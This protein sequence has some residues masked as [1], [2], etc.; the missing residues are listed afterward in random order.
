MVKRRGYRVE[1]GEIE[2]AS[3]AIRAIKE[4]AVDRR[5]DEEAGVSITRVPELPRGQA[6]SLIELKR[7]CSEN[8]PLYMIPERFVWLDEL[9]KTSTDKVDYQRAEGARLMDFALTEEQKLLRDN[10]VSSPT[11]AERRRCRARPRAGVLARAVAKVREMAQGPAGA[12]GVRRQRRSTRSPARSP[13]RRWA[14]AAATAAWCSRSART[15]SPAWC[16]VW[17]ARQRGAEAALPAGPVRRHAGR[18]A[19]DDRAGLG[20]GRLRDADARRARRRRLAHQRHQDLHLQRAGGGR[21]GRV[22]GDRSRQG[23]SRRRHAFLVERGSAGLRRRPEVRED[24]AAHLAGRRAGL[25]RTCSR[26]HDAVLG[27]VGGGAGVFGT[28]MDWER[29]LPGRSHVGAMERLLETSIAYARTRTQF[30]QAIG[31][32]QAVSH[33]IADMKVQLEAARA[34]DLPR[35]LALGHDRATR[36]STRRSTKLF[37]SE[38]LVET[39][40][41]TVQVHGGYGYHDRVRGRAGAARRRRSTIYSGTS[42]MQRNI[43]AR[44]LGV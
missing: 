8:L 33:S 38:S 29:A 25:R 9:P 42:E 31:K 28:A 32:F 36:R 6:P 18:R 1:L 19:R 10:I 26:G 34:A 3:T 44:W 24:G 4:A 7:F 41:D 35:G 13:S 20:L 11:R 12:G 27:H 14:T 15:C 21:R 17:H 22:R 30:G 37:V 40:L 39:A 43:I 16:R 23:L 5:A 2:A